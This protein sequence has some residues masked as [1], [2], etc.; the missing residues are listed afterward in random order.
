MNRFFLILSLAASILIAACNSSN[1]P[2]SSNSA[3]KDQS[4]I[5]AT[6][7]TQSKET[8]S[9]EFLDECTGEMI[10]YEIDVHYVIK[11][12]ENP[13]GSTA[14]TIQLN[15]K[16][17]GWGDDSGNK[18]ELIEIA[19]LSEE[20]PIEGCPTTSHQTAVLRITT[21][22]GKNNT[23]ITVHFDYTLDCDNNFTVD[24]SETESSCQ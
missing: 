5:Q 22:G 4:T 17:R 7:V 6:T 15:L 8:F 19:K 14:N 9:G 13:D 20:T 11:E 24:L 23:L 16:G 18:Y 2:V 1:D 12:I 21:P 10:S 3:G